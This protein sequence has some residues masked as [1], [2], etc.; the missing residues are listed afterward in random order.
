MREGERK[1]RES[2]THTYIEMLHILVQKKK[3]SCSAHTKTAKYFTPTYRDHFLSA[4]V[5][6]F[7]IIVVVHAQTADTFFFAFKRG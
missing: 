2:N 5:F 6:S 3:S 4:H 1:R 7:F